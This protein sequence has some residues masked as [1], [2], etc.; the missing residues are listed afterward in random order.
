[1]PNGTP[2]RFLIKYF[3]NSER[4]T[5]FV[6]IYGGEICGEFGKMV[7]NYEMR[8]KFELELVVNA[9]ELVHSSGNGQKYENDN[10][11]KEKIIEIWKEQKSIAVL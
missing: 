2:F 9:V 3:W 5:D 1:M 4:A 11:K 6:Y 8:R 7:W 10:E